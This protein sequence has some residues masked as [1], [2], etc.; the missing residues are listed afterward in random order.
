MDKKNE[1]FIDWWPQPRQLA[2]ITA[3]GLDKPFTEAPLRP[4]IADII[5]YGGSA[6]G[7]KTD[8]LLQI[9]EIA[10]LSYPKLN[11]GYFRREFPQLE[12]PG[13]AIL[14]S[15]E[16]FL[17]VGKYNEQKHRWTLATKSILQFCHCKDPNDVYNYQ[18][19][20][21]DI[22]LIDEVTQFTRDMVKYLLTR[23]RS[24]VSY[25]TFR[26]FA[27]FGTNPGNVG[28]GYFK[29]EFV[30]LGPPEQVNTFINEV[31]KPER[32]IFIPS[33]LHDNQILMERDPG[34]ADRV[35][36]TELNKKILLEG[37]WDVFAGQAFSEL[38]RD[39]HLIKPFE[40][41]PTW[42][43]FGAY[44]H[45]YNHPFSFGVFMVDPDGI[46]Y[47]TNALKDRLKRPDE[48]AKAMDEVSGGIETLQI[49]YAGLDCWSRQRDGGP[50]I[51]EQFL[52][53]TPQVVLTQAN[54]DRIQGVSQMRS[55]IAW[56]GTK[57]DKDNNPIN[58][59]PRFYIFE[60][61]SSVYN[62]L[63]QMI[64]DPNRPEDVLKVDADD[65]G[66]GGDDEYDMTRYGLMSRP[67]PAAQIPKPLAPNSVERYIQKKMEER[68][69]REEYV[70]Y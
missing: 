68:F 25:P 44:D 32:H 50:T 26:P 49:I 18:S 60:N 51:A 10:G 43:K 16:M 12:G 48:I 63:T 58:G 7:G 14:R 31:G 62:T 2:C 30:E 11:I 54:T 8:T 4:A 27:C 3:C 47:L 61:C 24:T 33:K 53:T 65:Q 28:H 69:I 59:E 64:F 55:F 15:M 1:I 13:G 21:F 40:V 17:P 66:V 35:G 38:S 57:R 45:G 34:Y 56:K 46:V 41:D 52:E 70:G 39:I 23:N 29:E 19:Q 67:R 37:S 22:L 36:N 9:G 6:G 5:G 20:Q 42:M